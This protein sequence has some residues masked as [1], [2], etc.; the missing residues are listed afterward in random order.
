MYFFKK[1]LKI[2]NIELYS[3]VFCFEMYLFIILAGLFYTFFFGVGLEDKCDILQVDA[4]VLNFANKT[5]KH[6][7]SHTRIRGCAVYKLLSKSR[8]IERDVI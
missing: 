6:T 3:T 5:C 1:T 2:I 7:L 4:C 8:L